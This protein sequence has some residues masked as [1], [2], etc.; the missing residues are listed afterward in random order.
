VMQ[1]YGPGNPLVSMD[2]MYNC[3]HDIANLMGVQ[4]F[5]RYFTRLD[6]KQTQQFAKQL[7][8][9]SEKQAEQAQN[10]AQ[11]GAYVEAAKIRTQGSMEEAKLKAQG[12]QMS[13]MTAIQ[14]DQMNGVLR[15]MEADS[16][17]MEKMLELSMND[18]LSR[19]RMAQELHIAGMTSHQEMI[20]EQNRVR[21]NA[22]TQ[23]TDQ[24]NASA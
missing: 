8:E 7:A 4:N 5:S 19:D 14:R 1:A 12:S 2:Q 21:E 3:A 6:E 9:K 24:S 10:T 18:D 13:A 23:H 16:D 15:K 11:A 17:F 22:A 20:T